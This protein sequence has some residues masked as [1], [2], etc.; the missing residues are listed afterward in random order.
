MKAKCPTCKGSGEIQVSP[1]AVLMERK[2]L[3]QWHLQ[4]L[5]GV[6]QPAISCMVRTGN[7]A[8]RHRGALCDYFKVTR[9]QLDGTAPLDVSAR[10]TGPGRPRPKKK[11]ARK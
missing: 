8:R 2:G 10:Q 6:K 1:L 9:D 7:I 5:L 4:E 3:K 11:G